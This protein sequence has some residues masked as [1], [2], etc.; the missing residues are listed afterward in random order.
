LVPG[1]RTCLLLLLIALVALAVPVYAHPADEAVVYHYGAL[2]VEKGKVSFQS[3]TLIGGLL[4]PTVWPQMDTDENGELSEAEQ[5]RHAAELAKGFSLK[6]D[7][8]PVPLTLEAYEYPSK[9]EFFGRNFPV[10]KL[11]LTAPLP[12]L[13]ALGRTLLLRD[14]TYPHFKG[15]FPQPQLA[16]TH[17]SAPAPQ[18]SEDGREVRLTV[19]PEGSRKITAGTTAA[20][21]SSTLPGLSLNNSPAALNTPPSSNTLEREQFGDRDLFPKGSVLYATPQDG[22]GQETAKLKDFL[23]RPLT[24]GLLAL[25]LGAALL[26]GMVHALSPGHGKAMVSAYLVG[27]RG[28][29]A[30]AVLLGIVVTITHTAG[31]YILGALAL[32]L[33]SR[34][35]AEVVGNWLAVLSGALVLGMGFWLFQRGLLAYHGVKPLPGHSHGGPFGHSHDHS[36]EHGHEHNHAHAHSHTHSHTPTLLRS[37]TA[38]HHSSTPALQHSTPEDRR[39]PR[40]SPLEDGSSPAPEERSHTRWGVISLGI[41]GGLVPCFDALAVLL[42]AIHLGNIPLGLALI[43]AFSVG[44]AIVLALIGVL[45]ITAKDLMA[46]FTGEARWVKVLPAVSGALLFILG[47]WLTLKALGDVGL[48]KIG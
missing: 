22:H 14:D 40:D 12:K 23:G 10:V 13:N 17:V 3:A 47:A 24:P 34:F 6:I 44:M 8:K 18:F 11:L 43:A 30:D 29:V 26:A 9:T 20:E 31:V 35:Q 42:A 46:R 32:W 41:A 7:G 2:G 36:H 25:A 38:P 28:T 48:V 4:A 45:M 37:H 39:P 21:P 1:R 5:E 33:T 19:L 27:S 16:L 15:I